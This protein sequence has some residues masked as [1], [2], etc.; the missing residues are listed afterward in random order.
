M[1][2]A[3]ENGPDSTADEGPKQESD[4]DSSGVLTRSKTVVTE[5]AGVVVD[6][7]IDVL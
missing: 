1:D 5:A 4:D 2:K 6:A 3:A 7:V